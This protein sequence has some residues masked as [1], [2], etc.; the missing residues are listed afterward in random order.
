MLGISEP[1]AVSSRVEGGN[2][3]VALDDGREVRTELARYP[4]LNSA[5]QTQL[6][7]W[8][9]IGHGVGIHWPD[10]DEDLSVAGMLRDGVTSRPG[11]PTTQVFA[12]AMRMREFDAAVARANTVA[13]GSSVK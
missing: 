7:N 3:I 4:R 2:L 5:S 12:A 10:V 9:L 8:R 6:A 11:A 13:W 1:L